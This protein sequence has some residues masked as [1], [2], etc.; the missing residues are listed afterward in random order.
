MGAPETEATVN[1][2]DNR[3]PCKYRDHPE[4]QTTK[5]A[6]Q[7]FP[8]VSA[9]Q[10]TVALDKIAKHL[11]EP[12]Y[13]NGKYDGP[14]GDHPMERFRRFLVLGS[15]H[16]RVHPQNRQQARTSVQPPPF[17]SSRR[18]FAISL[19]QWISPDCTP[20][21]I[22]FPQGIDHPSSSAEDCECPILKGFW[23]D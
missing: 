15:A 1:G 9:N 2:E 18:S 13:G 16:F 12:S 4:R 8:Q 7:K 11:N 5:C 23:M 21:P 22:C 19:P 3:Q 10:A 14:A 20:W 6:T 17:C